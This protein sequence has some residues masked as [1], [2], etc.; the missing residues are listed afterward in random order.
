MSETYTDRELTCV[1]CNEAFTFSAEEQQHH[2]NMGFQNE[3]KRCAPC[4]AERKRRAE[5]G[6][7]GGRGPGAG[8]REFH[9][10]TC[11]ECG[12]SARVPFKPRGDRP[13]YC[14]TCFGK[15]RR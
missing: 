8:S 15:Q 4:R 11:S 12:G 13:V 5:G 14:S 6:G 3:P 9:E 10:V 1:E 2:A 7:G